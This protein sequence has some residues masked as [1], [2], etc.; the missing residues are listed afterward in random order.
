MRSK[1]FSKWSRLDGQW[2]DC[3]CGVTWS[4]SHR[5]QHLCK[6]LMRRPWKIERKRLRLRISLLSRLRSRPSTK[7]FMSL[8]SSCW[9]WQSPSNRC[10]SLAKTKITANWGRMNIPGANTSQPSPRELQWHMRSRF[11]TRR[12]RTP[13]GWS[14]L[15]WALLVKSLLWW[16]WLI[17]ILGSFHFFKLSMM[18]VNRWL[19][20]FWVSAS[21]GQICSSS[22]SK[23]GRQVLWRTVPLVLG[24][25]LEHDAVDRE[26]HQE[27]L[28]WV[29]GWKLI[30]QGSSQVLS[31]FSLSLTRLPLM[32]STSSP[33]LISQSS[34]R[35][36]N[37]TSINMQVGCRACWTKIPCVLWSPKLFQVSFL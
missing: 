14:F 18:N 1:R 12:S 29:A 30:L 20:L 21:D 24:D 5:L 22:L 17:L 28:H 37:K 9:L 16:I 15:V 7:C 27:S 3:A 26:D 35:W 11:N 25:W 32:T 13:K 4:R 2:K 36:T 34:V 23:A 10:F 8:V 6:R 33:M 31:T 19:W